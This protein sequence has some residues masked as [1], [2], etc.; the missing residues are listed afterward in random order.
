[1]RYSYVGTL[2]AGFVEMSHEW[3]A[4]QAHA[5]IHKFR[6]ALL[7]VRGVERV[8]LHP[9]ESKHQQNNHGNHYQDHNFVLYS[10]QT[11]GKAFIEFELT[12]YNHCEDIPEDSL[13]CTASA[14]F[15]Q[16]PQ[17]YC[18]GVANFSVSM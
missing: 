7:A 13:Q 4:G 3:S 10:E 6:Q 11:G 1:M 2:F 15:K 14:C 9:K 16:P 5:V 8:E 12:R 17:V 18:R